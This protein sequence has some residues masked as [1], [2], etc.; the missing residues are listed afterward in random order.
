MQDPPASVLD[1]EKAVQQFECH[2]WHGEEVEGSDYLAMVLEKAQPTLARVAPATN[3]PKIPGHTSFRDD[4]AEL[5]Q[6]SVDLGGSPIRVFFGQAS[7][8]AA[9][10]IGNL[11]PPTAR[12]RAPSPVETETLAMPADDGFRFDEDEDVGPA[13]PDAVQ[14]DPEEP[15]ERV[16]RRPR[17]FP[18]E[19]GE[20]LSQGENFEGGVAAIAEEDADGGNE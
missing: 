19:N 3:S 2:G 17:P 18:L 10:F 15:V 13:G 1:D 8:Q 16:Q 11:R 12:S 5:L 6:F 14:G 20:L 9:D 4:E 7:D